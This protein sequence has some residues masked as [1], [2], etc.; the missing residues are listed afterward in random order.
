MGGFTPNYAP[1]MNPFQ[2]TFPYQQPHPPPSA[3]Y[4]GMPPSPM[5]HFL[6][7]AFP[8]GPVN[9][10]HP[11]SSNLY[12]PQNTDPDNVSPLASSS[13][14][15]SISSM[16]A[17]ERSRNLRVAK[18][19]PPLQ[20]MVGPLLRYDTIENGIWK[21]AALIVSECAFYLYFYS[22]SSLLNYGI[23]TH[24]LWEASDAG[25]YY[26]PPPTLR[27]YYD[28]SL[29]A[30]KFRRSTHIHRAPSRA[31]TPKRTPSNSYHSLQLSTSNSTSTSSPIQDA[32]GRVSE[33]SPS[34]QAVAVTG[35]EI[36]VYCGNG[37]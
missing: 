25:S 10:S 33:A 6:P 21:G 12:A 24:P 2:P 15:Q 1:P 32:Y 4:D 28:H 14:I 30:P 8:P 7:P 35:Q 9:L 34:T 19:K 16:T 11:Q 27:F 3:R 29:P 26:D 31:T 36:W 18:M 13:H 5:D 37:G 17:L 22:I 20:F 23:L